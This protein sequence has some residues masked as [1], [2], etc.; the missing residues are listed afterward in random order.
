MRLAAFVAAAV[1]ASSCSS[2]A[3]ESG[4]APAES[5]DRAYFAMGCFWCAEADF[6]KV[7]G[8]SEA[9]SGYAGG[10]TENPTYEQVSAGG[11]G[12]YEAVRVSYDPDVVGYGEL[13]DIFWK[14]VDPFDPAGQFCDKG[15][16]YRA[17]IFPANAEERALARQSLERV[18]ARFG[19]E[20]AVKIVEA[21]T[22]YRAEEYHQDYS[23][24]NPLRY[25]FYRTGCGR[26]AR[27][28][29]VWGE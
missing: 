3:Q 22:F 20:V 9:V 4:G 11:T 7:E 8:V 13:L 19:R 27:L 12:H 23:D 10:T 16:S 29:E 2:Y 28:Q 18:E 26:D 1:L 25:K 21:P 5:E 24:K 6:E 14:N 17:A 15:E